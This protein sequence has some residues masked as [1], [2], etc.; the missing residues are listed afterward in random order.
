M[1]GP[2][3]RA[4]ARRRARPRTAARHDPHHP[5]ARSPHATAAF[6]SGA[7]ADPGEYLC[8]AAVPFV[9]SDACLGSLS[10][11][12]LA[13]ASAPAQSVNA[14][15]AALKYGAVG[16]NAWSVLGY[17][18]SCRGGTWGAHPVC[19]DERDPRARRRRFVW[20]GCALTALL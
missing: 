5:A 13:P 17:M 11:S 6:L 10:C 12:I 8:G 1:P 20:R 19:A 9:N 14:A 4:A 3:R 2:R 15:V 16:V 18:A 7:G